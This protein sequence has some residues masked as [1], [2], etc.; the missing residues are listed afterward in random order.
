MIDV[1]EN[2]FEKIHS[3]LFVVIYYGAFD[4]DGG[5][6]SNFLENCKTTTLLLSLLEQDDF[7]TVHAVCGQ[8]RALTQEA[9]T[10]FE[11]NDNFLE[12][13]GGI[14]PE[15]Q[16][17]VQAI[18]T[19]AR[20]TSLA[21]KHADKIY[22]LALLQQISRKTV[23]FFLQQAP[24]MNGKRITREDCKGVYFI[25]DINKLDRPISSYAE[26]ESAAEKGAITCLLDISV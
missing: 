16:L 14:S 9:H 5:F 7:K 17:A 11:N 24:T 12:R 15:A 10:L 21:D 20:L 8:L 26:L 23:D 2:M 19:L 6:R 18:S 1:F 13:F 22:E 25:E 4:K 3:S